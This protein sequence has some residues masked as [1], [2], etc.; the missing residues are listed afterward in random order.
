M[1]VINPVCA[2]WTGSTRVSHWTPVSR[3]PSL[4][5]FLTGLLI[6][7]L[8]GIL[9]AQLIKLP[10]R[11]QFAKR[12][13]V[14]VCSMKLKYSKCMHARVNNGLTLIFNAWTCG[15]ERCS[16]CVTFNQSSPVPLIH[17]WAL[18]SRKAWI[19]SIFF[20][21][22]QEAN[23]YFCTSLFYSGLLLPLC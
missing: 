2:K 21:W 3:P 11:S 1:S 8:K 19:V 13:S 14:C 6:Y 16:S 22:C 7:E 4:C 9:P 20:S 18:F 23:V 17:L 10:V 15:W 5:V 12:L